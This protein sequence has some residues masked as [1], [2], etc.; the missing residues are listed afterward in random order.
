METKVCSVCKIEKPAEEF[1]YRYKSLGQRQGR[2]KECRKRID[3]KKK[4]VTLID[5]YEGSCDV[6]D[7]KDILIRLGYDLENEKSVHEQFMERI[8]TKYGGL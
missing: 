2:C 5:D 7:A 4:K 8:A 6:K 1:D 3:E